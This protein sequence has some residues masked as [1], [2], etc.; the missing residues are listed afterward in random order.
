V[1]TKVLAAVGVLVVA[2]GVVFGVSTALGDP[3]TPQIMP[4]EPKPRFTPPPP[5]F[6]PVRPEVVP[7]TPWQPDS[8]TING[9]EVRLPPGADAGAVIGLPGP[10][11]PDWWPATYMVVTVEKSRIWYT[12][13]GAL[14]QSHVEPGDVEALRPLL[15]ELQLSIN[16]KLVPLPPGAQLAVV[17]GSGPDYSS[18]PRS[19]REVSLG[20]SRVT[21]KNGDLL[22]S[23]IE[24]DDAA[25][26]AP[27]LEALEQ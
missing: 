1:R 13:D 23:H 25:A 6:P 14:L 26:L 7:G 18:D 3:P 24:P 16:G 27:L 4:K 21:F 2:V 11:T 15:E 20:S 12:D 22:E 9:T 8:V 17:I 19:Y 5:Q 10:L